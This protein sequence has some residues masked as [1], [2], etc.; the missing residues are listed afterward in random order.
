MEDGMSDEA[1]ITALNRQYVDAFLAADVAWYDEHLAD[2]FVCIESNG[3]VLDK[4]Q[5]LRQTAAG[6]GVRSYVLDDARVRLYGDVALVH[7]FGTFTRLDGTIGQSRY[8][9][10][11][12]PHQRRLE[13]H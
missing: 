5:F 1:T 11:L 8:T 3:S 10:R 2:D 9:E 13:S 7:G 12:C 6:P 4:S